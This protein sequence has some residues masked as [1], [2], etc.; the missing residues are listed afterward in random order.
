MSN[1]DLTV[2]AVI[3]VVLPN[4]LGREGM[5]AVAKTQNS[6]SKE[7]WVTVTTKKGR[8]IIPP[9]HYYPATGK[10]VSWNVTALEVNVE[11]ETEALVV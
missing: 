7:G 3:K 6:P 11:T 4:S 2:T 9:G 1:A 8:Q 10:T 5:A